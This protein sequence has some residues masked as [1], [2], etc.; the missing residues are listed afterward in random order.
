MYGKTLKELNTKFLVSK[1]VFPN[2]ICEKIC[3]QKEFSYFRI[4]LNSN[5]NYLLENKNFYLFVNKGSILINKRKHFNSFKE[6]FFCKG[7]LSLKCLENTELY[8]FFF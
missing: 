6:I 5:L 7:F 3:N 1:S 8:I 2:I 4:Q